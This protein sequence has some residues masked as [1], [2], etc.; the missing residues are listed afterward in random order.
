MIA[1][2]HVACTPCGEAAACLVRAGWTNDVARAARRTN[3]KAQ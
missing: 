1:G 2:L 3:E